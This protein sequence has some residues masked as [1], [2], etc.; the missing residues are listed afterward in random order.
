MTVKRT[1]AWK[2][3]EARLRRIAVKVCGLLPKLKVERGG[4]TRTT[5][6]VAFDPGSGIGI[7]QA[8]LA[9]AAAVKDRGMTVYVLHDLPDGLLHGIRIDRPQQSV[10]LTQQVQFGGRRLTEL[11]VWGR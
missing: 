8:G 4:L 1:A 9:L 11:S 6:A 10:T 7:E 5:W 3:D 2:K